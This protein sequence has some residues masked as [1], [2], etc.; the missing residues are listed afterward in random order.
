MCVCTR[1]GRLWGVLDENEM[2]KE[3]WEEIDMK[4]GERD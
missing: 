4:F 2:F 1:I 3:W